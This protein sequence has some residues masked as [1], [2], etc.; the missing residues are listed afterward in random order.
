MRHHNLQ[1]TGSVVV[2]GLGV[3]TA[4]ELTSYT[5]SA[6]AKISTL[7][8]F[9]ASVGTTNTF[10]ASASSRLSSIEIITASNIARINSIET[11]TSSNVARLNSIETI[12]SSNIARLNS[13]E[14]KTG[15]LATTGSNTFI[16]TQTITGSLYIS[17]DL[18]VQGSS[19]LQNI[20]AS[21]VSIGTNIINLNTA[22]PAIRYAGLSIGDSGSVGGSGSF[23]YDS[24]QDEF[25]FVHR[26]ANTTVTSS[27]VLMG[28]QTYDNVGTETYPTTNIIQKGTGNEHLVDSC[29][30][31]NG[32]TTCVKNNFVSTGT[33]LFSGQ[34]CSITGV[35]GSKGG[36]N[37][38][39]LISD[40]DQSNVRLRFTNSGTGGQSFSIVGG[41]PAL[42]NAGLA[43]YDET[44]SSTRLYISS[45]GNIS[46]GRCDEM[47]KLN[48][49]HDVPKTCTTAR[50]LAFFGSNDALA[51]AP[52]G[53]VIT[54]QGGANLADRIVRM[55]TTDFGS[56]NGG[57]L[58]L[59]ATLFVCNGSNVGIGCASPSY[60]LDVRDGT[61]GSVG[62]RGMRLST[63]SNSA[64]PQFR[65]EYQCTGDSRNWLI[66]TNQEVAGDFNIRSSTVA[67]CDPGGACSALRFTI[68]KEGNVGIGHTAPEH[69][70]HVCINTA[71]SSTTIAQFENKDYTSGTRSYARVR[72]FLNAGASYS[73][74]FGQGQDG[75]T[76]IYANNTARCGDIVID[77]STGYVGV[78]TNVPTLQM[79]IHSATGDYNTMFSTTCTLGR[80]GWVIAKPGSTN[81]IASALV[82]ASDCSYRLGGGSYYNIKMMQD[83]S[84]SILNTGEGEAFKIS[85]AGQTFVACNLEIANGYLSTSA[86]SGTA[87]SSRISTAYS[88]PYINTFIDSIAGASYASQLYF[89][90]N[91]GG[92][93][94]VD[95]ITITCAGN[96]WLGPG[97][98]ATNHRIDKAVSQ[99]NNVLVVSG[100]DGS[101]NDT[102]IFY[103]VS[104]AGGNGAATAIWVATNTGTGR[105]INAGGT[106]NASGGDYAEY[107]LKRTDTGCIQKGQIVGIDACKL[108]TDK[109]SLAHS[110]VVKSTDPSYVGG[111]TWDKHLGKRPQ[112]TE[113]VSEEDFAPIMQE[114][115]NNLEEAR[116]KVDRIAFSGQVPVIVSGSY[117]IGDYILPIEGPNDSIIGVACSIT[118]L[119]VSDYSKTIGKVWGSCLDKAWVA[120]KIG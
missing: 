103:G 119:S 101:S 39:V 116:Q 61:T 58:E 68:S 98:G 80:A 57:L 75:K 32:T 99:G 65:L 35:F 34:L 33:G 48:I 70:L 67:G 54:S 38:G 66:G 51:S 106:I 20:T 10:T 82:L 105:S 55:G 109:W 28:P 17:S 12:T 45:T 107:M 3:A 78:G 46:V 113:D 86:G 50:G 91:S 74:Y 42:S 24:V 49:A 44:N 36:G 71:G 83:G 16:G 92:G 43:F 79:H 96:V 95:R 120:V 25:I 14:I 26:G 7:Q 93:G 100:Y 94:M 59:N 69:R 27:V 15:S 47:Y 30:F 112:R 2:N 117:N 110:F 21:A 29:I 4:T 104:G 11:I 64:G 97:F 81:A 108:L 77:G 40:N 52:F 23:L 76:Y 9:T 90:T 37:Y 102:A 41:N 87:Y 1:V 88:Y 62:G 72:S 115:E 18:I 31:D 73:S 89:R 53:L 84:T 118:S 63:C 19:S 22:N 13:L 8:S 85:A 111:D 56:A 60:I 114:F 6:D 5:A